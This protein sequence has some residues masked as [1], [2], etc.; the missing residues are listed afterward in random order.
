M[1]N[2]FVDKRHFFIPIVEQGLATNYK[3]SKNSEMREKLLTVGEKGIACFFLDFFGQ[4]MLNV[5]TSTRFYA[6][7]V[8]S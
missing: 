7:Q 5:R 4:L 6:F 3:V 1:K 2:I 8:S